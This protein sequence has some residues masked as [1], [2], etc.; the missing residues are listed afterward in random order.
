MQKGL[1]H[2]FLSQMNSLDDKW[3]MQTRPS[4]VV[5]RTVDSLPRIDFTN[6]FHCEVNTVL[7]SRQVS[8]TKIGGFVDRAS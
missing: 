8:G 2:W 6:D 7:C 1:G 3:L 4:A 5:E